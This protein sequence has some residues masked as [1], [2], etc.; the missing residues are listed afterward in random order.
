MCENT[1]GTEVLEAECMCE[2]NNK[3]AAGNYCALNDKGCQP[4]PGDIFSF[5]SKYTFVG[6]DH[7]NKTIKFYIIFS[8]K[9]NLFLRKETRTVWRELSV[10]VRCER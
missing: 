6:M 2:G 4:T 10:N 8:Q 3:C 9:C 5:D 7:K 1:D